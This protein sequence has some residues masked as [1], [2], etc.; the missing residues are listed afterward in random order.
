MRVTYIGLINNEVPRKN[1]PKREL[2]RIAEMKTK[3]ISSGQV[4]TRRRSHSEEKK[5]I[6]DVA[7]L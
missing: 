4:K 6:V 7:T 1:K 3:I 2:R 5:L